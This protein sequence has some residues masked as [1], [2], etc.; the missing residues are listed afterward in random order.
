MHH[1]YRILVLGASYG[2]LLAAKFML[3][4]HDVRL[5]C[6]PAEAEL[7]NDEGFRVRLPVKGRSNLVEVDSRALPG[8]V[9]ASGADGADPAGFDLVALAMQEPQYSAPGVRDLL[10]RVAVAKA[11]CMSIM[12][13]PPLTYLARIT[14]L[15]TAPLRGC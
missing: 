7:I 15:A 3:A 6:L 4:N 14:G 12:N 1:K 10:R 9:S 13:M 8:Q 2:S 5:V 11:P